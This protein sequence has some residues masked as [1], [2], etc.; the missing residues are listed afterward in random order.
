MGPPAR[1]SSRTG[2]FVA[3][4]ATVGCAEEGPLGEPATQQE[5]QLSEELRRGLVPAVVL[6]VVF[7]AATEDDEDGQG[8]E[9]LGEGKADQDGQ[10]QPLVPPAEGREGVA[11]ADGVAVAAFAVDLV[12]G[13]LIDGVVGSQ[14]DGAC[15]DEVV[16]DPAGQGAGEPPR[17]PAAVGEDA[18]IIGGIA[19]SQ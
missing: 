5:Q 1:P 6:L 12:A 8:P 4:K 11:A 3:G 10:D 7:F 18:V 19:G 16:E 9:T 2:Q 14:E 13:V 17:G 15:T